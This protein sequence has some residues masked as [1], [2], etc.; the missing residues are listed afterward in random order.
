MA[1][2]DLDTLLLAGN[3]SDSDSAEELS[4]D[5]YAR[6]KH[7]AVD[8]QHEFAGLSAYADDDLHEAERHNLAAIMNVLVARR[9]EH[10]RRMDTVLYDLG[11]LDYDIGRASGSER[12]CQYVLIAVVT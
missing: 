1:S 12:V 9:Q 5:G 7:S 8:S 3:G 2:I 6:D 11:G 10:T 4:D